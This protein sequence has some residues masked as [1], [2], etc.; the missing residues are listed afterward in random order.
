LHIF[1]IFTAK[2]AMLSKSNIFNLNNQVLVYQISHYKM[3]C[4]KNVFNKMRNLV[5]MAMM[6]VSFTAMAQDKTNFTLSGKVTDG[7]DP[8]VGASVVI[9]STTMGSITDADGNYTIQ[10]QITEGPYKVTV[11]SVGFAATTTEVTFRGGA[12]TMDAVLKE[13]AL[14]LGEVL[15]V[16]SSVLQERKQ[17]GNSI[18]TVRADQLARSG[19]G[20]AIQALQGKIAGA[21]ITQNS[22]DPAGGITVRLRGAKSLLGSS[23]PLYVIDG[24]VSNNGTVNVTNANVDGG[25][26]SAI[27]QNR[28]ADINP[29]DIETIS[30]L[31]GAAA[32]AIYGSRASNGVVVIT[33]KRGKSGKPK[34]SFSTSYSFSELRKK[35]FISTF[36]KQ[37]NPSDTVAK[38]NPELQ[39]LYPT[40]KGGTS[41]S[42]I[43]FDTV[44]LWG[45]LVDV[46]RF[47]YQ[48]DI[49][50][51]AGGTDNNLSIS[52]GNDNTRYFASVNFMRNE[53][54][55]KN[56]DFSRLSGRLR[57]DQK[58]TSWLDAS[59]GLTYANGFSNELPNGNVFFSPTNSINITNNIYRIAEKDLN[60][61]YQ[62]VERLS[63]INPY[64]IIDGIKNSQETNR[65]I[66][67]L[68]FKAHPLEGLT[69]SYLIGVDNT[70]QLGRNF[71]PIFPYLVNTAYFN[72]GYAANNTAIT[73]LVNNDF[74]ISYAKKFGSFS[75]NTIA[76]FNYL[77]SREQVSY[78]EGRDLLPFVQTVNGAT[79]ALPPSFSDA[80]SA[81]AGAFVQ[82][83]F[84]FNEKL[85]VTVAGRYDVSSRYPTETRSNFYPKVGVSYLLSGESFWDGLKD[86]VPQFRL[87]GA[88][89]QT[90]NVSGFGV[91]DR[92]VRYR[93]GGFNGLGT[94]NSGS[95]LVDPNVKVERNEELEIGADLTLMKDLVNIGF[96]YYKNTTTDL[97]LGVNIA[98]SQGYTNTKTNVGSLENKGFEVTLGINPIK[99]S[100]MSW[101][102]F[103]TFSHNDNKL[104]SLPFGLTS[105]SSPTGAPI[106]LIEGAPV[107]VFYGNFYA[108]DAAGAILNRPIKISLLK[109][110]KVVENQINNLP[111]VERGPA[112]SSA[113]PLVYNTYRGADGEPV[114]TGANAAIQRKIIGNPNP[115]N[116]WSLGTNFNY[117]KL[118]FSA[119]LDAVS[120]VEVWNADKR[121]RN[122]V[123][124]G[125]ESERELTG[126]APR[127]TVAA[128]AVIEEFRVDDGSYIKLREM[129]LSYDLGNI[130]KGVDNLQ[131]MLTGRNLFSWDNYFGYDPETNATGQSSVARGIDFGNSPIPRTY[132]L[133]VRASF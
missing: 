57:L 14:N 24:V 106:F 99:T 103:G 22:G 79:V 105:V 113:T 66:S 26:T 15:V 101:N 119:L 104:T 6:L 117:G 8:V 52:G 72:K 7:T 19:T 62:P 125:F 2:F 75:T 129:S 35:S 76:G 59:L 13:D 133:M 5:L 55:V 54:I 77:F 56:T 45:G 36:G 130:I 102:I 29:N 67:D 42:G 88:W 116:I 118:T 93:G 27:G 84:G 73:T 64:S 47:D 53:G 46:K 109:D 74:N 11:S 100:K 33:T 32:A 44:A 48:D 96:N 69:I 70:N 58:I 78:T 51:S 21:Q 40:S 41:N 127:G 17:L 18:T 3:E 122:N 38:F 90:G 108:R 128:L 87:R 49:F 34:I 61:N 30:V 107:G 124:I 63:R 94:I 25:A 92:F 28:M 115:R 86:V 110:G 10:G 126:A 111:Q 12:N 81:V 37:F 31:S 98:P 83:T 82:E 60:G 16:G 43:F 95:S 97:L 121:T 20:N 114:I 50:R 68:S 4:M 131:I 120:G 85:F 123:G 23:E 65:I 9:G 1:Y 80:P 132:Q 89:G 112:Q 91:Y 39:I 71:S